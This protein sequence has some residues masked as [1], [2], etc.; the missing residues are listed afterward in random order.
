MTS[1]EQPGFV[2][3]HPSFLLRLPDEDSKAAEY[4]RFVADLCRIRTMVAGE[5]APSSQ[6]IQDA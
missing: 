5:A 2:T 4:A 6:R 3:V 1:G